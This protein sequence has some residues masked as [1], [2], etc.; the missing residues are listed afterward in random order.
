M[1]LQ[2][3]RSMYSRSRDAL[4]RF[5][6]GANAPTLMLVSARALFFTEKY[7]A[8]AEAFSRFIAEN[9]DNPDANSAYFQLGMCGEILG[10]YEA[11]ARSF[12]SLATRFPADRVA[13][14]SHRAR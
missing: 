12:R 4:R 10:D 7:E 3:T 8:A 9:P 13:L 11:A 5:P 14:A 6:T 1:P 2:S